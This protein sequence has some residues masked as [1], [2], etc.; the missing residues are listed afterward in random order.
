MEC[1]RGRKISVTPFF[2]YIFIFYFFSRESFRAAT[3]GYLLHFPCRSS[4]A[5]TAEAESRSRFLWEDEDKRLV[6]GG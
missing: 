5:L 2:I 1:Y 6:T 3:N 4:T